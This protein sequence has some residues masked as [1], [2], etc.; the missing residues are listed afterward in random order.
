[1]ASCDPP[2]PGSSPASG[3]AAMG[4]DASSLVPSDELSRHLVLQVHRMW[5]IAGVAKIAREQALEALTVAQICRR[6]GVTK[7]TF[8]QLFDDPDQCL[9]AAFMTAAGLARDRAA[10]AFESGA[11]WAERVAGGLLA[12]LAFCEEEPELASLC[13]LEPPGG[14]DDTTARYLEAIG[15]L[16][17]LVDEGRRVVGAGD[18]LPGCARDVV[19]SA[20]ETVRLRL[21]EPGAPPMTGLIDPLL[22]IVLAPYLGR[23]TGPSRLQL[24]VRE[25]LESREGQTASAAPRSLDVRLAYPFLELLWEISSAHHPRT[26]PR[27]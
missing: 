4:I 18:P 17:A 12:F 22:D 26:M 24:M 2:R 9:T 7:E 20:S 27:R 13:V 21:S 16:A 23:D 5:I 15:A 14:F 6:A 10:P 3:F 1:M 19:L 8:H 25:R 11:G